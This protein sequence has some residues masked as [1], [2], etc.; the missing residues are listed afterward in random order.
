MF[1]RNVEKGFFYLSD[2]DNDTLHNALMLSPFLSK[3]GT[4]MLQKKLGV[5]IQL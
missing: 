2:E 1:C 5:R 4:C 3:W